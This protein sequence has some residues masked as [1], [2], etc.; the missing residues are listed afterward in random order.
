MHA[1]WYF[2]FYFLVSLFACQLIKTVFVFRLVQFSD[3][4]VLTLKLGTYDTRS[5]P[6]VYTVQLCDALYRLLRATLTVVIACE[7]SFCMHTNNSIELL[8]SWHRN[9]TVAMQHIELTNLKRSFEF[10]PPKIWTNHGSKTN[11]IMHSVR[12]NLNNNWRQY[13]MQNKAAKIKLKM[14]LHVAEIR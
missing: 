11:M 13:F 9:Y 8:K 4:F 2:L 3:I 1:L 6:V 14:C 5:I 7:F 12:E 10:S